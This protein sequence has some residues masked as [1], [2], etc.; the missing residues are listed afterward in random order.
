MPTPSGVNYLLQFLI[1]S[2]NLP[3]FRLQESK[4][5]VQILMSYCCLA[6]VVYAYLRVLGFN[7]YY[8]YAKYSVGSQHG[9]CDFSKSL[10]FR[11]IMTSAPKRQA[12]KY[13]IAS[14]KSVNSECKASSIV[15]WS[16]MVGVHSVQKLAIFWKIAAE[17]NLLFPIR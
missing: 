11:V 14:S 15:I 10:L 8:V 5:D 9:I 6:M 16:T 12:E 2:V 7:S 17:S 1:D 13:C 3:I 4:V